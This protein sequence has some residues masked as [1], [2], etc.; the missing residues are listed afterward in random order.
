MGSVSAPGRSRAASGTG[1]VRP[2]RGQWRAKVTVGSPNGKQQQISRLFST[3][4]EAE[5][6][7]AQL[8]ADVSRNMISL[9][10]EVLVITQLQRWSREKAK[11]ISPKTRE[12]NRRQ[13]TKYIAP[14]LGHLRLQKLKPGDIHRFYSAL[15]AQYGDSLLRQ[16]RT[17]LVQA[18][19]AAVLDEVLLRNPAKGIRLPRGQESGETSRALDPDEVRAF[20]NAADSH[21]LSVLPELL[22]L[23][24]LR[25]SEACGLR[26]D[27]L[28]LEQGLLSVQERVA[29][30]EGRPML[31]PL[32]TRASLR[33]V[34]LAPSTV[35]LLQRWRAEQTR[36]HAALKISTENNRV[37][38][39]INGGPLHPDALSRLVSNLGRDAHL[40]RV[41]CHDLRHTFAS[42]HL[43]RGVPAEV[44]Q[45]WLGHASVTVTLD[46]YRHILPHEHGRHVAGLEQLLDQGPA[47][48]SFAN[49]DRFQQ[50][51]KAL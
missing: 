19:D 35:A 44:V 48:V 13:I 16:V 47:N 26:W 37:F 10:D 3:R 43:A 9:P 31:G 34:P 12:N 32:K 21:P 7:R 11:E 41:R 36:R 23:T 8:I 51:P 30:V 39:N 20:L 45:V 1:S 29:M 27:H 38:T 6:W 33:T 17:I 22:I 42:L 14:T 50:P 18:F 4:K 2:Y 15:A 28:D 25:R 40:G 46:V 5:L 49:N 24:G